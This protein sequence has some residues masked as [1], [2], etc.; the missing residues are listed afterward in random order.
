[1]ITARSARVALATVGCALAVA[2][3]SFE[4][5]VT[6]ASAGTTGSSTARTSSSTT[7]SSTASSAAPSTPATTTAGSSPSSS[8]SGSASSSS[9]TQR[10]HSGGLVGR[11]ATE[12]SSTG[13]RHA[14]LELRNISGSTCTVYGYGGVQLIDD[15]GQNL[16]THQV[17]VASPAPTPVTVP[18]GG[19]ATS[20]LTW[21]EI[22]GD[23]DATSGPC[24]PTPATLAVIP[25]DETQPLSIP[26]TLGPVCQGGTLDQQT[27]V[28]G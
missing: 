7:A 15:V 21:A 3:C 13:H 12:D 16:P 5:S 6:T 8:S 11:L 9:S 10:C 22:P 25:P 18:A 1:M 4:G 28:S 2:G 24:Q 26:W 17:R 14:L 19:T 20:Q 23:G 27:Y